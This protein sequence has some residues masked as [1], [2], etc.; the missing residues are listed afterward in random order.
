MIFKPDLSWEFLS[1][2]EIAAKTRRALRNHI[3]YIK[4]ASP[5]YRNELQNIDPEHIVSFDD[6]IR[7]PFTTRKNLAETP[8]RFLSV[9]S[10]KIVETV[11]TAGTSKRPLPFFL[12]SSDL[13]RAAFSAALSFRAMGIDRSDRVALIVGLDRS[14]LEGAALYHGIVT[15]GANCM[16]LGTG[17]SSDTSFKRCLCFFK[18]TVLIGSPSVMQK[19][20]S[21]LG[22]KGI[23]SSKLGVKKLV[24]ISEGLY[25]RDLKKNTLCRTTESLWG[26]DAFSLYFSTELSASIG[27]CGVRNGCH[28]QPEL[29]YT[30]IID[31]EGNTL[32]DGEAGELVVTPLGVEGMP[33]LRYRTGDITFKIPGECSCGRHSCRIGPV[34]GQRSQVFNYNGKVIYPFKLS[35]ALDAI[36]DVKDYL[37]ILEKGENQSD[38]A[39]IHAAA[40]PASLEKIV[41]KIR[42]ATGVHIPVL[43]SNNPTI[44]GMRAGS[45]RK[46]SFLD[47]RTDN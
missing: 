3:R 26:A 11:V 39:T 35:N 38:V 42:E 7:L 10:E 46:I 15:L 8:G 30:E 29:V 27:E 25:T 22:K 40:P 1:E 28:L 9:P 34:L 4:E 37:I 44:E 16:R 5:Y 18:P 43:I 31:E 6:F 14:L 13:E 47:K 36:D 19:I 41:L 20:A 2:D 45:S 17:I 33:L 24:C 23:D 12:T 32:P 21:D